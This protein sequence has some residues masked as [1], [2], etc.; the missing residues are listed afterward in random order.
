MRKGIYTGEPSML[1][2]EYSSK[3]LNYQGEKEVTILVH[4]TYASGSAVKITGFANPGGRAGEHLQKHY[5]G[6][7]VSFQW[8]GHNSRTARAQDAEVFSRKITELHDSGYKINIVTHSHGGNVAIEAINQ[9]PANVKIKELHTL[10]RP[11]REYELNPDKVDFYHFIY[12]KG[13]VVKVFGGS[14]RSAVSQ[15]SFKPLFGNGKDMSA[16]MI[17]KIKMKDYSF[18]ASPHLHIV[19]EFNMLSVT[20]ARSLHERGY[21][22]ISRQDLDPL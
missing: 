19:D 9:L 8:S 21:L 11:Y 6:E 14:R 5:G 13:D 15:L 7:V 2:S 20:Q 12:A 10:A 18:G 4:G 1:R 22:E 16:D 3:L 17:T